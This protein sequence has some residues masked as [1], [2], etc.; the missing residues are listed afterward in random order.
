MSKKKRKEIT[1]GDLSSWSQQPYG[2]GFQQVRQLAAEL[3]EV[4]RKLADDNEDRKRLVQNLLE[5]I[6]EFDRAGEDGEWLKVARAAEAL[7]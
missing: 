1:D 5:T 7:R 6:D 3:L 2:V 4:R